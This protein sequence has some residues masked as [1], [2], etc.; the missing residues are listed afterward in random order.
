MMEKLKTM[1]ESGKRP[2]AAKID[3]LMENLVGILIWYYLLI[4]NLYHLI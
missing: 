1:G 4:K 2:S 3:Q